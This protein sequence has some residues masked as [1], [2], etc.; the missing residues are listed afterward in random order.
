[1]QPQ[2]AAIKEA[3]T[4]SHLSL[5]HLPHHDINTT[6]P[7][8]LSTKQTSKQFIKRELL[9][10]IPEVNRPSLYNLFLQLG[11]LIILALAILTSGHPDHANVP[12]QCTD[13]S[14]S[15]PF[16]Y[17]LVLG[18]YLVNY[19]SAVAVPPS[20]ENRYQKTGLLSQ[21]STDEDDSSP[22]CSTYAGSRSVSNLFKYPVVLAG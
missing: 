20:P 16:R 4:P 19:V 15:S 18:G 6:S 10:D 22:V 8:L 3:S 17:P 1:M 13:E 21:Q 5:N 12:R 2:F 7:N 11:T 14:D 9:S